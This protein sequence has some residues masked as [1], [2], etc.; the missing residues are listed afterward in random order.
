[1]KT[2]FERIIRRGGYDLTDT[3]EKIDRYHNAG[4]LTDAERDELYDMAREMAAPQYDVNAE[5]G[6]LWAAI[7]ELRGESA[8]EP[9]GDTAQEY[10]Q[11]TGAHDAYHAGDAV[12]YNGVAYSCV[13]DNCV[14]A[15][16]VLPTAWEVKK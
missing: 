6:R 14:W 8:G 16:D 7:R 9:S 1:M 15:P 4:K 2:I 3:L 10:V 12:V 11:P 5:I 13:M